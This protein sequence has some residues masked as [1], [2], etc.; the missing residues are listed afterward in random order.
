VGAVPAR[1]DPAGF[2]LIGQEVEGLPPYVLPGNNY[3]VFDYALFW[4]NLRA[5]VAARLA[6]FAGSPS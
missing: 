2:L 3:H 4:A 1:C 5:D 6:T